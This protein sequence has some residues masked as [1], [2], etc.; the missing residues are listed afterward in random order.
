MSY[1]SNKFQTL[2]EDQKKQILFSSKKITSHYYRK[3]VAIKK[4][5]HYCLSVLI[6]LS[7]PFTVTLIILTVIK[8]PLNSSNNFKINFF[9]NRLLS[10][11]L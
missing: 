8:E 5:K 3:N 1:G 11:I 2:N 10:M 7:L 4:D 6:S 9:V